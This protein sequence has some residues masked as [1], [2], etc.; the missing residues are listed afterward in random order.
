MQDIAHWTSLTYFLVGSIEDLLGCRGFSG[1]VSLQR[2]CR[3]HLWY[4]C[5]VGT[6]WMHVLWEPPAP[7]SSRTEAVLTV[8]PPCPASSSCFRRAVGGQLNKLNPFGWS[9]PLPKQASS[10]HATCPE[11]LQRFS[12]NVIMKPLAVAGHCWTACHYLSPFFLIFSFSAL[13][14]HLSLVGRQG[15]SLP[16]PL[17]VVFIFP[18]HVFPILSGSSLSPGAPLRPLICEFP[19]SSPSPLLTPCLCPF[20]F[21]SEG[22][23][24]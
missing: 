11:V 4:P 22:V 15:C 18:L 9:F 12:E 14:F 5:Q 2:M 17:C 24:V 8:R 19:C 10:I 23:Q 20:S 7:G 1:S 16:C 13:S 3:A 21:P 6:E